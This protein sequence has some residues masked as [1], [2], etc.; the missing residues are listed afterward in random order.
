[1][2]YAISYRHHHRRLVDDIV[3]E[4][5]IA[6]LNGQCVNIVAQ[7]IIRLP[8]DRTLSS[9]T[10]DSSHLDWLIPYIV[11]NINQNHFGIGKVV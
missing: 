10:F 4:L 6:Y 8:V 7:L 5:A 2:R 9:F 3:A 1:M 11:K